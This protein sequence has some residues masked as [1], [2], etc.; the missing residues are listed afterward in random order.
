MT[1]TT[2]AAKPIPLSERLYDPKFRGIIYQVVV[3]GL[4]VWAIFIIG[5][6]TAANL[7]R[8]GVTLGLGFLDNAAGISV[9]QKLID[10]E[11]SNSYLRLL[12]VSLLNTLLIASTGIICATLLGFLVGVLRLSPN[13][14]LRK[15]AG[16]YVE[17]FRNVPLLLQIIFWYSAVLKPLSGPR[18][19]FELGDSTYFS[20][21]N[22]GILIA[23]IIPL[24]GSFVPIALL[25]LGVIGS[26]VLVKWATRRK[27]QTGKDFPVSLS[28]VGLVVA[29]PLL[30]FLVTGIPFRLEPAVMGRFNLAGGIVLIP[31]FIALF[32]AL[33]A[34]TAAFI[35]EI[36]RAGIQAVPKGQ[37]EAAAALGLR[38]KTI[39]ARII[40]PQA[41]RVIIPPLTSQF[42]NLTKNSS[43]A[44]AV[45]YPELVAV[46]AGTVLNQTGRAVEIMTITLAIYLL[47]SLFTSFVLNQYNKRTQLV[48][49]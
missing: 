42:L 2:P 30:G 10:F 22:R 49:R 9:I 15:V 26:F 1:S 12:L 29:L 41:M 24:S 21:N 31:E 19:L 48:E 46:F 23:D 28:I 11:R 7:N 40:I 6:N 36:V 3:L 33:V 38:R 44:A 13:W 39:L 34:Y 16:V 35:G 14:L 32:L 5:S 25:I 45:G 43:L 37:F 20:I 17:L 47:L 8:I 18:E 27:L 4:L